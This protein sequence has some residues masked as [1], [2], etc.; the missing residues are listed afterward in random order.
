MSASSGSHLRTVLLFSQQFFFTMLLI[1]GKSIVNT[2]TRSIEG[3]RTQSHPLDSLFCIFSMQRTGLLKPLRVRSSS[4]SASREAHSKELKPFKGLPTP[5]SSIFL[6]LFMHTSLQLWPAQSFQGSSLIQQWAT[7]LP[8]WCFSQLDQRED[9]SKKAN[10]SCSYSS[11]AGEGHVK[12]FWWEHMMV[13]QGSWLHQ[14]AAVFMSLSP[15]H[16]QK[17]PK[18]D[19]SEKEANAAAE[20]RF[21]H[22][23]FSNFCSCIN[24]TLARSSSGFLVA[25]ESVAKAEFAAFYNS[26]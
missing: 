19:W 14:H 11:A 7:P 20:L 17:Y 25:S 9:L 24:C 10:G 22:S 4:H 12:N 3:H 1:S 21:E 26:K 16:P 8:S 23:E 18:E 2:G 15:P 13:F 6:A 5:S